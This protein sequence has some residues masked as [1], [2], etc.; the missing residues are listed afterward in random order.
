M[1]KLITLFISVILLTTIFSGCLGNE[2]EERTLGKLIIAYEIKE[3]S[4]E[5][6]SNPEML[7]NYLTEKLNYDVSIFSVDSEGAMIEP[8]VA[9]VTA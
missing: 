8:F 3:S 4:Q 7:A 5:I 6:D 9:D 1:K 2:N